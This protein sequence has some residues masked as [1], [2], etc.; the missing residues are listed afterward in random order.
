LWAAGTIVTVLLF[1]RFAGWVGRRRLLWLSAAGTVI[2]ALAFVVGHSVVLTLLA[3]TVLGTAGTLMQTDCF[4][5]LS[6][7]HGQRRDR[8]L[9]E[10]TIVASA[11]AVISPIAL[12]LLAGT[13]AGWRA[14]L[15]LPVAGLAVLFVL[16]RKEPLPEGSSST[17][18][19]PSRGRLPAAYWFLAVLVAT[20]VAIE[21]CIV[22][23]ATQLLHAMDGLSTATAASALGLQCGGTLI[24]RV[25]SCRLTRRSGRAFPLVLAALAVTAMGFFAFWLSRAPWSQRSGC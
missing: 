3:A 11:V 16:F 18:D 20:A 9:V 10:G 25:L 7:Q 12:G 23:Y 4:S 5:V 2:G 24:G 15:L 21:F 22:F 14:G 13:A 8:A 6:D 19:G 17:E 1:E